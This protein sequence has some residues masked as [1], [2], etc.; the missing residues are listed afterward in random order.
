[1]KNVLSRYFPVLLFFSIALTQVLMT[2][3][4][5]PLSPDRM[6]GFGLFSTVDRLPLR[7]Y[8]LFIKEYGNSRYKQFQG[9][10]GLSS[11][12]ELDQLNHKLYTA[13]SLPS[14]TKLEKLARQ[15]FNAPNL[16]NVEQL[17]L[18]IEKAV[19]IS[20]LKKVKFE[21]INQ[22]EVHR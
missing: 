13:K 7:T 17:R 20:D 19:Y 5:S 3:L 2:Q 6:G 10:L 16:Q 1:M 22:V 12:A 14:T 18:Q 8:K 9:S 4:G 15:L 21:V 11:K